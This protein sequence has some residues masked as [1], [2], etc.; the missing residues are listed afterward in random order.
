MRTPS[1]ELLRRVAR[2]PHAPGVYRFLDADGSVIYVG[3]AKDLRRRVAQ[4]FAPSGEKSRRLQQL[5]GRIANIEHTVVPTEADALLLENNL[6]KTLQPRYNV[7]LKDD[8]SYPWV[9]IRN[10]PFPRVGATRRRT[11]GGGRY[12]GPYTS[13]SQL[14]ALLD[15]IRQLYP[16]RTC[17]HALTPEAIARG[18]I[19]P[20]LDHHIG[21]CAA[22]CAGRQSEADYAAGIT[23]VT[24]ILNGRL[25]EVADL[26][27]RRM[28]EA[29][30]ALRFEEAQRYK[31]R[32][33]HLDR[34]Q[35]R[36]VVVSTRITDVDVCTLTVDGDRAAGSFLRVVQGAVVG[37]HT[38]ILRL[39]LDEP[40]P[41]LLSYFIA[42]MHARLGALSR[43]L[44]VPF[45]PDLPLPGTRCVIPQ[46]GERRRLLELGERNCRQALREQRRLSA[47]AAPR[48]RAEPTLAAIQRDLRLEALP[49]HI[50]CFDNSNL[51]GSHPVSSCVVFRDGR[52]CRRDYRH[53]NVKTV[54]GADDFATMAEVVTRRY[55]R[56]AAEGAALPQLVVIDGG[57]G[58]LRAAAAALRALGLD[59]RMALV[60]LAKR[61]EE[62]Y[63]PGDP[64]PLFLDK[65][66]PALRLLMRLR[67]EAHRFGI[68]HHRRRRSGAM[69][70]SALTDIRGVGPRT[71]ERL[72]GAFRSV[73][74]IRAASLD[75]LAALVGP[76]LAAT[77]HAQLRID[78]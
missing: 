72:L 12:F 40:P 66:S 67:D 32:L 44:L 64:V 45:A 11:P 54:V 57:K 14:R 20:C 7:L 13:S 73:A 39:A 18:R 60:G 19:R 10:E 53:F 24:H 47:E 17:A 26:L 77:I 1:P 61:L 22:P 41:A 75:E 55:A 56:L 71:A 16:L 76:A 15:L 8:K 21:R 78:D 35:A 2:L 62:L 70:E 27:R 63:R 65:Q 23:A 6:I 4:Y 74:R 50:E 59:R 3:K 49:R 42:E 9:C 48:V 68:T 43:E 5:V 37:S 30:A 46:R 31:V 36:S 38:V 25:R 51:Q 33:E 58:Q 52:P 34:Y 69:L 29:A 28:L